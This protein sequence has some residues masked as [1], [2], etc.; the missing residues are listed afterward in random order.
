MHAPGETFF[1]L[2]TSAQSD[3]GGG[4][5]AAGGMSHDVQV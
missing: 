3:C 1:P 4:A 5:A 2:A